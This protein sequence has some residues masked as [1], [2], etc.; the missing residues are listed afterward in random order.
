[1]PIVL[2]QDISQ[3]GFLTVEHTVSSVYTLI[4][5]HSFYTS[6]GH[7][8]PSWDREVQLKVF[9]DGGLINIV[10]FNHFENYQYIVDFGSEPCYQSPECLG[11]TNPEINISQSNLS[12][13]SD[14]PSEDGIFQFLENDFL[15]NF[16]VNVCYDN[17]TDRW[18][19]SIK[20]TLEYIMETCIRDGKYT[21]IF[22]TIDVK[23]IP[24]ENQLKA[25]EDFF[26]LCTLGREDGQ[27]FLVE[28]DLYHEEM[29][30]NDF[31]NILNQLFIDS[32]FENRWDQF[33]ID[34][35]DAKNAGEAKEMALLNFKSLIEE[36][37]S[38]LRK[39]WKKLVGESNSEKRFDYESKIYDDSS[40]KQLIHNY[41]E[42]LNCIN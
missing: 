4:V 2:D 24:C 30:K 1:M 10:N 13:C 21:Y 7:T 20:N 39:E 5:G 36:F 6:L 37:I 40:Y 38:K 8:A 16:D 29:H 14:Y 42:L 22:D 26:R 15:E 27:Y 18:R 3:G 28:A 31:E 23:N 19:F 41:A 9:Q 35:D 32:D 11:V 17:D 33:I 34:C 25:E 12:L